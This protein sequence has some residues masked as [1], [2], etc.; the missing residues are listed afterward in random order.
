[1]LAGECLRRASLAALIRTSHM[2]WCRATFKEAS[3]AGVP[4]VGCA[5]RAG[6]AAPADGSAVDA[7]GGGSGPEA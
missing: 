1:M 5:S 3:W 4:A 7:A 6:G 2:V